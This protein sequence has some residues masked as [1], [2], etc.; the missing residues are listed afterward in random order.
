MFKRP[1]V[2]ELC[3]HEAAGALAGF[4]VHFALTGDVFWVVAI[5]VR[6][7]QYRVLF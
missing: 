4:M 5:A 6:D 7:A 3:D 2:E 1:Q